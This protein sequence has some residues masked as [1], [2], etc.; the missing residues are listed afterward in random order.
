[1]QEVI[2]FN[3]AIDQAVA[4]SVGYFHAH[5]ERARNLLLGM[6][7]HDM[8]TP[9]SAIVTTASYLKILNAGEQVSA[10]AQ[11]LIRSG[12]SIQALLDDLVDFNRS[13]LG[14]GL[15]VVTADIDLADA[16]ADELEQLRGAYPD[17]QIELTVTG[18][19]HGHWDAARSKQIL[20]NLVSNAVH[21]G[22]PGAP[23]RVT[24]V[25]DE[26]EVVLEVANLGTDIDPVVRSRI[27]EPL[28]RGL[29]QSGSDRDL[30]GLGLG[31]FIVREIADAHGGDVDVRSAGGETIFAVRL[32]RRPEAATL[33]AR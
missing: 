28:S 27:F 25:G 10:A 16:V 21:H 17:R 8:R 13:S 15:K 2:R 26:A 32:P 20:R 24:L 29:A 30:D 11:C 5:V 7:G 6:L 9:L 33:E 12:A 23:V 14:L 3:E 22:S 4:E 31:L 1:M 19:S 18:D